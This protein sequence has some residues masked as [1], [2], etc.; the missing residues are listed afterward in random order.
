MFS[1]FC[2]SS[3]RARGILIPWGPVVRAQPHSASPVMNRGGVPPPRRGDGVVCLLLECFLV[4]WNLMWDP[5]INCILW[6]HTYRSLQIQDSS[7]ASLFLFCLV[8][9][10][11][12]PDDQD[13]RND[14]SNK[15]WD[16]ELNSVTKPT[17]ISWKCKDY[18][19]LWKG[20]IFNFLDRINC[21]RVSN[22]LK[23]VLDNKSCQGFQ[24]KLEHRLFY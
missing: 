17:N 22:L 13:L 23:H 20:F 4:P 6:L 3:H 1:V 8:Y 18:Q 7:W 19:Y 24:A 2:P 14:E 12:S 9:L 10:C 5:V 11:Q 21:K 16:N 15:I